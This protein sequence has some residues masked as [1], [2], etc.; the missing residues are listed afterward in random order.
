MVLTAFSALPFDCGYLGLDV[1]RSKFH[2]LANLANSSV[3][4]CGSLSYISWSGTPNL[5]KT[6]CNSLIM[7]TVVLEINL[8]T[9]IKLL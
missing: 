4:N 5:A 7:Q 3:Q 6:F 1:I 9:S 8:Q 2:F